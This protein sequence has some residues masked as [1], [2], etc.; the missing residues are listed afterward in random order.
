MDGQ[1]KENYEV[2]DC[3]LAINS[4]YITKKIYNEK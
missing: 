4:Y 2:K 3:P 1:Y